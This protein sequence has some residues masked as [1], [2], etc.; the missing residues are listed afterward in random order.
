MLFFGRKKR[1]YM[2]ILEALGPLIGHLEGEIGPLPRAFWDDPY[3]LGYLMGTA[4]HFAQITSRGKLDGEGLGMV[5][6]AS[7]RTASGS[8]GVRITDRALELQEAKDPEFL[9]GAANSEKAVAI[10]L[11]IDPLAG[12]A[13]VA[14]ARQT[15]GNDAKAVGWALHELLLF[16]PARERFDQP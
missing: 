7:M 12:D 1:A 11:A 2:A 13:D 6:I 14:A 3:L 8:D 5:L 15:A 16:A 4:T 9:R 10:A